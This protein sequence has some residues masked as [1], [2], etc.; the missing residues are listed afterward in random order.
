VTEIDIARQL[1]A[2]DKST[3]RLLARLVDIDDETVRAPSVLP[4]WNRAMVITHLARNADGMVGMLEGARRGEV[5]HQYPHGRDGRTGDIEAGRDR[6]A[7]DAVADLAA[8]VGRLATTGRALT[9]AEWERD[10]E[11]FSGTGH[12]RR[13]PVWQM[14]VSRRREVEV[15]HLDLDLGY[16]PSDWPKDFVASELALAGADLDRRLR[17]GSALRLIATDGLGEWRAGPDRAGEEVV[18]APGGQLLAW[19]LGR[20]CTVPD[21]PDLAAWQ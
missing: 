15:H 7:A 16:R 3:D 20:P 21:P 1:A 18:E 8:A 12:D 9:P 17:P 2:I 13:F 19:L 14:L 5:V 6:G 4:G 11:A 10:A